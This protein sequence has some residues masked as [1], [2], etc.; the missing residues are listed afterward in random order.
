M[1]KKTSA[2][3]T[4]AE[5]EYMASG[6]ESDLEKPDPEEAETAGKGEKEASAASDKSGEDEGD[7]AA[8]NAEEPK[9]GKTKT[10]SHQALHEERENRKKAEAR[11]QQAEARE[12]AAAERFARLDERLEILNRLNQPAPAAAPTMPNPEEDVFGA[13]RY[14]GD[15]L[16]DFQKQQKANAERAEAEGRQQQQHQQLVSAYQADAARARAT[17]PDFDDAYRFLI[18][19]RERELMAIPGMGP[20]RV[21]HAIIN[22]EL[23]IASQALQA[24]ASPAETIYQIAQARG[25]TKQA[26]QGRNG[27]GNDA[28]AEIQR[29]N[30]AKA[31]TDSLSRGGGAPNNGKLS[32]ESLD[33]MSDKEFAAFLKK[34]GD[35]GLRKLMGAE[36]QAH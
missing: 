14:M 26:P 19:S 25:Y 12:K 20:D 15:Q 23:A 4:D 24:G 36:K 22:D 11:A 3:L 1:A 21:R 35:D 28:N 17:M 9:R 31:A 29:L 32:L 5:E 30:N 8:E 10:V 16:A 27:A 34:N 18:Q 13:V 2:E 33:R 7:E 6:G